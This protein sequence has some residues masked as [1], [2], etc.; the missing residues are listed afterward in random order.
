MMSIIQ[1]KEW[2]KYKKSTDH[3]LNILQ[4]SSD[5]YSCDHLWI[6]NILTITANSLNPY[7]TYKIHIVC[8]STAFNM[9]IVL[10]H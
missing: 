10:S 7:E 4:N 8:M 6:N 5:S 3:I 9:D 1:C 2:S